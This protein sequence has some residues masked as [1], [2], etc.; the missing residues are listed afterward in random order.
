MEI[1]EY[2]KT[3]IQNDNSVSMA[4]FWQT[5]KRK[6]KWFVSTTISALLLAILFILMVAPQYERSATILIKDENGAGGLLSSMASGMGML[7]GMAGIHISSNVNN[8]MEII[9]AP[10]IMMEV[11]NR[12]ELDTRYEVREGLMKHELWKETLPI[13][14]TFPKLTDKDAAYMK[15]DLKK[16]G[17][18]TLYKF[19]LNKEKYSEEIQGKLNTVCQT[20]VGPVSAIGT[21]Y[22][23][24]CFAEDSEITIRII[25][26]KKYDQVERCMKQMDVSLADLSSMVSHLADEQV[27]ADPEPVNLD[28]VLSKE[29][30][31]DDNYVVKYQRDDT[32]FDLAEIKSPIV[33]M[34]K[35]DVLRLVQNVVSN[36][37][38]HGF[39]NQ[40]E[41]YTINLTIEDNYFIIEF[42]NN[43]R[44]LPESIDKEHYG[45]DGMKGG[46]S[47]GSGTGGFV[48]KSITEHYGGDYDIFSRASAGEMLTYVI[49][50]LP[51]YLG[52]E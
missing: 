34:G 39:V 32:A 46:K 8:E 19:R 16:D 17:T 26:E 31:E 43:G 25:K 11:V 41:K 22:F 35:T 20:P 47:N 10:A 27:F 5:C 6:W 45:I 49:V 3:V 36:A 50:K 15:M 1:K 44:P 40:N 9:S 37:V 24:K 21:K 38:K 52:N 29:A 13:K 18:F 2:E 23:D 33:M 28:E 42:V 30:R 14:V 7:A 12:L 4:E 48:V 51:I